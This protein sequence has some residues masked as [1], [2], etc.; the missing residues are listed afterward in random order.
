MT[1]KGDNIQHLQLVSAIGTDRRYPRT[2]INQYTPLLAFSIRQYE[3]G[4]SNRRDQN[5]RDLAIDTVCHL[6]Q[7]TVHDWT[8]DNQLISGIN[9]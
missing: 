3:V 2:E 4:Q 7:R 9:P 8:T 1:T 6:L 5:L